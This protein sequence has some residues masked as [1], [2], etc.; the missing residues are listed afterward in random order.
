MAKDLTWDEI[1]K[2]ITNDLYKEFLCQIPLEIFKMT[3]NENDKP[4]VIN[5]IMKTLRIN[6]PTNA[7]L[8]YAEK[9]AFEMKKIAQT[10]I[11]KQKYIQWS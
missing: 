10:V 8:N 11:D 1:Q 2:Y 6:D 4:K 3:L 7:N 9:M 5:A